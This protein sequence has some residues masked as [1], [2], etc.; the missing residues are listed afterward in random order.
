M[1]YYDPETLSLLRRALD[2]AWAGCA[3]WF[4]IKTPQI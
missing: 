4:Q 3:G 2:D 1:A